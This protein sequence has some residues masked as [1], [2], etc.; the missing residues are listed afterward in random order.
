M[1]P[2]DGAD[3]S[4]RTAWIAL[5][6]LSLVAFGLRTCRLDDI[7]AN[8]DEFNVLG[9]LGAR[10]FR[11]FLTLVRYP[12]PE[13]VPLYF[14][15]LYLAKH[16]LG[17]SLLGLRV[18][19]VVISLTAIPLLYAFTARVYSRRAG[20]IAALFL[21]LSPAQLWH[22]QTTRFY[23]L[24]VPLTLLSAYALLR[25]SSGD[26]RRWWLAHVAANAAL[27]WTHVFSVFFIAAELLFIARHTWRRWRIPLLWCIV[28][29]A[30]VVSPVPWLIVAW[31]RIPAP[32]ENLEHQVPSLTEFVADLLADDAV[33]ANRDFDMDYAPEWPRFPK[34][35]EKVRDIHAPFDFALMACFLASVVWAAVR[36]ILSRGSGSRKGEDLLLIYGLVPVTEL[37]VFSI[38]WRPCIEPR[39][40]LYSSLGL[41]AVAGGMI[42]AIR[43]KA[44][45]RPLVAVV[46]ALLG[47]QL[48]VMIPTSATRTDW[49]AAARHIR[50]NAKPNDYVLSRDMPNVRATL[51]WF[52]YHMGKTEL[53]LYTCHSLQ[54]LCQNADAL[55]ADSTA[56]GEAA[57][58]PDAVWAA[59]NI[60]WC[61]SPYEEG[62]EPALESRGLAFESWTFPGQRDVFVYRIRRAPERTGSATAPLDVP[63]RV[64]YNAFLD[65]L[66]LGPFLPSGRE[67]DAKRCLRRMAE[68]SFPWYSFLCPLALDDGCPELAEALARKAVDLC[69]QWWLAHAWLATALDQL[70]RADEARDTMARSLE[71][72]HMWRDE[73]RPLMPIWGLVYVQRDDE[74]ARAALLELDPEL[75]FAH[76]FLRERLGLT[77]PVGRI[78]H[79]RGID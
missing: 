41:Y 75:Q 66:E 37:F 79:E 27:M 60:E 38:L 25:A 71:M 15:L 63:S 8:L 61:D 56:L 52:R 50:A 29:A 42:A 78:A 4:R 72:G 77:P 17:L 46:V 67:D 2:T 36:Q 13:S 43:W 58:A 33:L 1:K 54:A 74:A 57:P 18:V 21:A 40:T 19:S 39:F 12:N 9:Y 32:E 24:V 62:F 69:P 65:E 64:D 11:S 59:I 16:L 26:S 47:Y 68:G 5:A 28:H 35:R 30:V 10:G 51:D 55:L 49:V 3:L 48:A 44:V 14:I 31:D 70:G 53:R 22:A 20:L 73:H 6:V 76:Q 45:G 7:A 34:L 23:V